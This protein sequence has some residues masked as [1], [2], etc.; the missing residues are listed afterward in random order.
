MGDVRKVCEISTGENYVVYR[1]CS[2]AADRAVVVKTLA[3]GRGDVASAARLR[4]EYELLVGLDV[5][6]VV[7]PLGLQEVDG[8]PALVLEPAGALDLSARLRQGRLDVREFLDLAVQMARSVGHVHSRNVVHRDLSPAKFVLDEDGGVT[9]VGFEFATA[10]SGRV[11][12]GELEGTLA[13]WRPS[14]RAGPGAPWI[15]APICMRSAPPSTRCWSEVRR[16]RRS[17]LRSRPRTPRARPVSPSVTN[18]AIPI[19]SP[20]MVL[21]LLAKMPEERYQSAKDSSA[22]LEDARRQWHA[23]ARSNPSCSDARTW[24]ASCRSPIA[25]SAASVSGPR[26]PRRCDA[27]AR[28]ERRSYS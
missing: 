22:D 16:S 2:D 24:R 26:S 21:K 5:P 17:G 25:C 10:L 11:N 14:R 12:A 28:G 19:L 4:H 15:T 6:G 20:S 7:R 1:A 9:L 23:T 3:R 27:A 13:Y 18:A 8:V